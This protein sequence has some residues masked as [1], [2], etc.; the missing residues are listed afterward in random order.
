MTNGNPVTAIAENLRRSIRT[1]AAV[2]PKIA[3]ATTPII[4]SI[5]LYAEGVAGAF[6][7]VGYWLLC[8]GWVIGLDKVVN[9]SNPNATPEPDDDVEHIKQRYVRGEVSL[10]EFEEELQEQIADD[11]QPDE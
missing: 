7:G 5:G 3:I 8:I 9:R 11:A 2:I 6:F 10:L 4:A 1:T